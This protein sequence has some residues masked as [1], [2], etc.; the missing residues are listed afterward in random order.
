M[1]VRRQGRHVLE[2]YHPISIDLANG[3][4]IQ[5]KHEI[6]HDNY[7]RPCIFVAIVWP[8][9]TAVTK[10]TTFKARRGGFVRLWQN[11]IV[12][13]VLREHWQRKILV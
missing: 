13:A 6:V 11:K 9:C 12:P 4:S 2:R 7:R 10:T 5:Q 1:P 8:Y 3:S